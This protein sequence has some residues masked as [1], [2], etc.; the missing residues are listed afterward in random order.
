MAGI[1]DFSLPNSYSY[2]KIFQ[3]DV[4]QHINLSHREK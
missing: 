1:C 4:V 2:L 3:M